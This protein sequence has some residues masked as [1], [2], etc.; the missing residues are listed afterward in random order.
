MKNECLDGI[1]GV[2]GNEL[3]SNDHLLQGGEGYFGGKIEERGIFL[4]FLKKVEISLVPQFYLQKRALTKKSINK[5]IRGQCNLSGTHA[6][7]VE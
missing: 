6:L 7:V 4:L 1:P 3:R 5:I 2:W